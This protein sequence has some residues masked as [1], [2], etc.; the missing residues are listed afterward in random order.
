MSAPTVIVAA[1]V[2][3]GP[4]QNR[5]GAEMN[6]HALQRS[7]VACGAVVTVVATGLLT[8]PA[9]ETVT[10]LPRIEFHQIQLQS[11]TASATLGS[12]SPDT[13]RP[14]HRDIDPARHDPAPAA[15]VAASDDPF[16]AGLATAL[17][18][19]G[20]AVVD[21]AGLLI[22]P[23]WYL[24]FPITYQM[25]SNY[26]NTIDS[27]YYN[28]PDLTGLVGLLRL[29]RVI[30]IWMEFPLRASSYLFPAPTADQPSSAAATPKGSRTVGPVVPPEVHAAEVAG[31]Q[32]QAQEPDRIPTVPPRTH[33]P[34]RG[35]SPATHR[36]AEAASASASAS[37]VTI[38]DG[39]SSDGR[40]LAS[41]TRA[42]NTRASSTRR[43][44]SAQASSAPSIA[45]TEGG[46]GIAG[47]QSGA[48][49]GSP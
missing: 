38:R 41:N 2:R 24:A 29:A 31:D 39:V 3:V 14:D 35:E 42:S 43:S 15:A 12:T 34:R 28:Y 9:A 23:L 27:S 8:I 16:A 30:G 21:V 5:R 47:S 46:S 36:A 18:I 17:D 44:L 45:R 10:A 6:R 20:R 33:H 7:C 19:V 26:L 25:A 40:A 37:A 1:R 13:D 11:A 49:T 4:N 22:A 32:D 48:G